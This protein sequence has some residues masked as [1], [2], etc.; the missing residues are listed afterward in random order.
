MTQTNIGNLCPGS[1][2][3]Y[4]ETI[5]SPRK[6]H[7]FFQRERIKQLNKISVADLQQNLCFRNRAKTEQIT[8]PNCLG[9]PTKCDL[10]GIKPHQ[11]AHEEHP[12]LITHTVTYCGFA[13]LSSLMINL[14]HIHL[15]PMAVLSVRGTPNLISQLK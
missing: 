6:W 10:I 2:H 12:L 14:R 8:P 3:P 5:V 9:A 15:T 4:R 7:F 11:C 1:S 13:L